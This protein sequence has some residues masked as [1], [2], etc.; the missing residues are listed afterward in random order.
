MEN[1]LDKSWR[2]YSGLYTVFSVLVCREVWVLW[3]QLCVP[4]CAKEPCCKSSAALHTELLLPPLC[5]AW[6]EERKA[7]LSWSSSRMWTCDWVSN[8]SYCFLLHGL[9]AIKAPPAASAEEADRSL[10]APHG[11]WRTRYLWGQEDAFTLVGDLVFGCQ[12]DEASSI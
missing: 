9:N 6:Q 1:S 3:L 8:P 7:S 11:R 2:T 10:P 4:V 5:L 12:P